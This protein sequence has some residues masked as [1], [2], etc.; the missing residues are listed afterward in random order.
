[1]PNILAGKL[2][3][4]LSS[5]NLVYM[6]VAAQGIAQVVSGYFATVRLCPRMLQGVS[7]C[8]GK[9]YDVAFVCEIP[10]TSLIPIVISCLGLSAACWH[11]LVS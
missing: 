4:S 2:W 11:H 6:V 1:M 7:A 9:M 5:A 3:W 8:S 10:S